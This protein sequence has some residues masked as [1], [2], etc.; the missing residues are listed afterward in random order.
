MRKRSGE[1][2]GSLDESAVGRPTLNCRTFLRE[3]DDYP[4]LSSA[5]NPCSGAS[6]VVEEC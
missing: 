1:S 3:L 4:L 5:V 2:I 6:A